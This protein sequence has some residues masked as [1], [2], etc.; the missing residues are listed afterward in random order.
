MPPYSLGIKDGD[1][2]VIYAT[3]EAAVHSQWRAVWKH[4]KTRICVLALDEVHCLIDW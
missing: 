1:Y 3:P 4:H 2:S